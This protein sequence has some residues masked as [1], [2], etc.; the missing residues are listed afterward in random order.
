MFD[1]LIAFSVRNRLLVVL[2]AALVFLRGRVSRLL[3]ADGGQAAFI[4]MEVFDICREASGRNMRD[5]IPQ[6]E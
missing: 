1:K 5:S 4:I 3:G 2:V 6:P